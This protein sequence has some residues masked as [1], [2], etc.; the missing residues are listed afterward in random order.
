M[1]EQHL[2]GGG[3]ESYDTHTGLRFQKHGSDFFRAVLGLGAG[4]LKAT[5]AREGGATIEIP[6]DR[7]VDAKEKLISVKPVHRDVRLA[8]LLNK[9]SAPTIVAAELT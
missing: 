8:R 9:L 6:N 7:K 5:A 3:A 1:T 2:V 4:D